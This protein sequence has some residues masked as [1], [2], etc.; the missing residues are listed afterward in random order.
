MPSLPLLYQR[1]LNNSG[2]VLVGAKL[3]V[4]Q[5]GTVNPLATY[6]DE[7]LTLPNANPLI[8]DA[9]GYFGAVYLTP[10][11]DYKFIL[12]TAADATIWTIDNVSPVQLYDNVVMDSLIKAETNPLMYGAIGDGVGN[13]AAAVQSAINASTPLDP[14]H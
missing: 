7:A 1:A 12:K 4:Y 2:D 11:S 5:A 14:H 3:Y 9:S 6:S 10:T 13:E 8:S